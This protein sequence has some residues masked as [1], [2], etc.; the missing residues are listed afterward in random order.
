MTRKNT[1]Y[2]ENIKSIGGLIPYDFLELIAKFDSNVKDGISNE[3]YHLDKNEKI[4]D[5]INNAYSTCMVK[6]ANFQNYRSNRSDSATDEYETTLT[7]EKWLL[8]LFETLGFGRLSKAP[9]QVIDGKNY[10]ITYF[11]NNVPIHC[12]GAKV[13]LDKRSNAGGSKSA[14]PY[15]LVQEFL[16]RKEEYLW[17]IVTNGLE[18]RLL[19]DN[20]SLTKQAYIEFN[21]ENIFN[22]ENYNDFKLFFLLCHQSRMENTDPNN[23]YLEKWSKTAQN[24]GVAIRDKLRNGVE[25]A[26]NALGNAFLKNKANKSLIELFGQNQL[27]AQEY[28]RYLLRVVYRLLFLFVAEDKD[29]LLTSSANP[30]AKSIYNKYYSTKRLR[31]MANYKNGTN[32]TDMWESIVL[33]FNFLSSENGCS[34]LGLPPLGS[35]L[36][37][38]G[39]FKIFDNCKITNKELL[40]VLRHL[41]YF[42]NDGIYRSVQY[43]LLESEE[44]GSIYEAL[45]EQNPFSIAVSGS[46]D[47]S[48]RSITGSRAVFKRQFT[49]LSGV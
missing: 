14:S 26:I 3:D 37:S 30:E 35:F 48:A 39:A 16:N 4:N 18:L 38:K 10:P 12:V 25:M 1:T 15:S 46:G 34:E 49:K 32:H 13:D 31:N 28:Y 11:W 19:R 45:L 7:K 27:T 20:A 2:F 33:L 22:H 21:L 40:K 9:T 41:C 23:F 8:P 5:L 29:V 43:A 47:L 44:F 6:W 24:T 36:W 17:A 42:E